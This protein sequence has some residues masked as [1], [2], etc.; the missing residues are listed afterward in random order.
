M[1]GRRV[2]I[3]SYLLALMGSSAVVMLIIATALLHWFAKEQ[4]DWPIVLA[5]QIGAA[6]CVLSIGIRVAVA[7]VCWVKSKVAHAHG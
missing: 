2:L 1:I 5:I 6:L 4:I 7:T 3:A